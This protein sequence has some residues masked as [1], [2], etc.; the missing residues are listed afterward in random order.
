M[1]EEVKK[2]S[3]ETASNNQGVINNECNEDVQETINFA[4]T[5]ESDD[6]NIEM[7]NSSSNESLTQKE[8]LFIFRDGENIS[9]NNSQIPEVNNNNLFMNTE[10]QNNNVQSEKAKITEE[11]LEFEDFREKKSKKGLIIGIIVLIGVI[12]IALLEGKYFLN[13]NTAEYFLENNI[14]RLTTNI[15]NLIGSE[16]LDL[17]DIYKDDLTSNI[18]LKLTTGSK[19]LKAYNNIELDAKTNINLYD[20]YV[21]IDATLKQN[22]A[23]LK[24]NLI[25][26]SDKFYIDSNDIYNK[27]L[28]TDIKQN[29]FRTVKEYLDE[30]ED[31][32][33]TNDIKILITNLGKY[34]N[35]A[36]NNGKMETKYNGLTITYTYEVNDNNKED[37]INSL[38]SSFK[39]DEIIKKL[40]NKEI[41]LEDIS[42]DNIKVE[43]TFNIFNHELENGLITTDDTQL[44]IKKL[45]DNKYQIKE[46]DN[47]EEYIEID[48]GNDSITASYFKNESSIATINLK[49]TDK[50]LIFVLNSDEENM[51][52]IIT[53]E[54]TKNIKVE[55]KYKEYVINLD[56]DIKLNSNNQIL[57]G[58]VSIKMKNETFKVT[59]TTDTKWGNSLFMKKNLNNTYN[60]NNL[61][62]DEQNEVLTNIL[63][64]STTFP[65]CSELSSLQTSEYDDDNEYYYGL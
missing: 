44:T 32:L 8:P 9:E 20:N 61:T 1:K 45:G 58:V 11:N 7:S 2:L 57:N 24:G 53:N 12:I 23:N 34:F 33:N 56:I 46:K 43:L 40:S 6:Q 62:S 52:L 27:V 39:N 31:V 14:K 65:F 47:N 22:T 5:K 21:D 19:D 35:T 25:L 51:N 59:F 26:T 4:N 55:V 30:Y 42:L 49:N 17:K 60:M 37:I 3:N 10:I 50:E 18:Y 29:Y 28:Y 64:K 16:T 41:T 36:L 38:E 13:K 48:T 63:T 15:N 54:D